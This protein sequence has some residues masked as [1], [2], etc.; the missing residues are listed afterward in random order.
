MKEG[1]EVVLGQKCKLGKHALP[2]KLNSGKNVRDIEQDTLLP[3]SLCA[4]G[5]QSVLLRILPAPLP[6]LP[7]SL[8]CSARA[9]AFHFTPTAAAAAAAA[10]APAPPPSA[11]AAASAFIRRRWRICDGGR[12]GE[13][14]LAD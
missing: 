5:G 7:P 14:E 1:A 11:A 6:F 13:G 12:E 10:T 2:P 3:L 8:P 4:A 9:S